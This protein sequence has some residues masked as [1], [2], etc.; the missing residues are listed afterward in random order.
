MT[1][2]EFKAF[3]VRDPIIMS[4][5]GTLFGTNTVNDPILLAAQAADA[6]TSANPMLI[7]PSTFYITRAPGEALAEEAGD[8]NV[9]EAVLVAREKMDADEVRTWQHG[10]R[11]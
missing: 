5:L 9:D 10:V 7:R 3:A 2:D 11:R 6:K 1:L 8:D 4:A